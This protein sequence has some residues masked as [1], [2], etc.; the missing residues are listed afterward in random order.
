MT[1]TERYIAEQG[2]VLGHC[3]I[4]ATVVDT[5][6]SGVICECLDIDTAQRIAVVLNAA[7]SK[8]TDLSKLVAYS[9]HGGITSDGKI[10]PIGDSIEWATT[11]IG[12]PDD[13]A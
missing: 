3:C 5:S 7:E 10:L 11:S 2:S 4:E 1:I 6:N 9:N 12:N 8:I 13:Q